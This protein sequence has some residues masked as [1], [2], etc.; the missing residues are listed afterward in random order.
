MGLL[1][2]V[3]P[4]IRHKNQR[5]SFPFRGSRSVLDVAVHTRDAEPEADLLVS[6][7]LRCIQL[8]CDSMPTYRRRFVAAHERRGGSLLPP[9]RQRALPV[10]QTRFD[11]PGIG[12]RYV[13]GH[14]A[15]VLALVEG[16]RV[17]KAL[18]A[19]VED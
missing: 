3:L 19:S 8:Q 18:S 4:L 14:A 15:V 2:T 16:A 10:L 5:H 12:R 9:R 6:R 7:Y 1:G 11:V 17:D 13:N